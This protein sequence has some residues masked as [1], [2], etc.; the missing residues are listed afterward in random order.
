MKIRSFMAVTIQLM[1]AMCAS[2]QDHRGRGAAA[3]DYLSHLPRSLRLQENRPH[4]YLFTCDYYY[5]DTLGNLTRKERVTG[6]YTRGLPEGKARWNNVRIAAAKG[7]ED[8]FPEGELQKYMEGFTYNASESSSMF[9]SESFPG[10][11]P[12]EVKA[13]NLVWDTIGFEDFAWNYFDKLEL[14][15][16][17]RTQSHPEDVPLAGGGTFQ[18]HQIELV[19]TGISKRNGRICALFQYRAFFNKLSLSVGNMNFQGRSHYWGDIWVSLED[20]Q[21]EYATLYEDVLLEF[22]LP[23]QQAR[24]SMNPFRQATFEKV[25]GGKNSRPTGE[26]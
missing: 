21:I 13:K 22:K 1:V 23:G 19:W 9:T 3:D 4:R 2:G 25:E 18:N 16:V 12:V 20:K 6:E 24:Q 8:A 11:P 15:S 5:L 26:R 17:Y 10:F 14:N 7:F